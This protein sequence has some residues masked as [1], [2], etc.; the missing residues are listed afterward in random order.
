MKISL[1]THYSLIVAGIVVA[2]VVSLASLL[3]YQFNRYAID[4][5][6][7]SAEL[8]ESNLEEQLTTKGLSI[9]QPLAANLVN[10]LYLMDV[11]RIYRILR[12]VLN[13]PDVVNVSVFDAKGTLVHDGTKHI[14][15]F[16]EIVVSAQQLQQLQQL[17]Q[18]VISRPDNLLRLVS[19]IRIGDTLIGGAELVLDAHN[20]QHQIKE[21]DKR[22]VGIRR[23]GFREIFLLS[24][25]SVSV[26]GL[27][28]IAI[29]WGVSHR[30][31]G[32]IAQLST[33]ATRIGKGDYSDPPSLS[34]QDELGELARVF[35]HTATELQRTT[36]SRNFLDNVIDSMTEALLVADSS[37]R[38]TLANTRSC[39][40]LNYSERELLQ[41]RASDVVKVSEDIALLPASAEDTPMLRQAEGFLKAKGGEQI[42]AE[43]SCTR[44][45]S[46]DRPCEYLIVVQDI[47]E[48]K[49]SE[50]LI[51]YQAQYD[52]LT[53]LPNRRLLID[54]LSR[55][56]ARAKRHGH[57]GALLFIDLDQFKHINDS[58]G[59]SVGDKLLQA[60]A[61]RLK[62]CIREEDSV[63]RLGGD[64]FVIILSELSDDQDIH[65]EEARKVAEKLRQAIAEPIEV[66]G[67]KLRITPSIGIA[68]FPTENSTPELLLKY[69]DTA[70]YRAKDGGRNRVR[71]FQP[72]MQRIAERRLQLQE[73]LNRAT[74][75]NQL[76]L[77]AQPLL[78][79][80]RQ[81]FA[82]EILLRWQHPVEGLL[83]PGHFI[84]LAEETG[85]ILEIGEWV[86]RDSCR[87]LADQ[88]R[89]EATQR[90]QHLSVNISQRQFQHPRFVTMVE[91]IL[92]GSGAPPEC[93]T[94]ELTESIL[95]TNVEDAIDK[96]QHLK[97]LGV[98]FALDDFG[99]GYSSLS[100]LH[101]LPLDMIK[102]DRSF[103]KDAIH[104][105]SSAKIVATII[106]LAESLGLGVIAEGV[107]NEHHLQL[108]KQIRCTGYQG[109]LFGK[110]Q[111]LAELARQIEQSM[112]R[113][114]VQHS[115]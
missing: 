62:A 98:K 55:D 80:N 66:L 70:M 50:A 33:F 19:P 106:H 46:E 102:I 26:L 94:L 22:M 10:P 57:C 41:L 38:I 73:G 91:D 100:Y 56:L 43:I 60:V 71:F 6:K 111:P 92:R 37:G 65:S 1:R 18:P 110:P 101:R 27:L 5:S 9:V 74:S 14:P 90:L 47:T 39:K 4:L 3:F 34:R 51:R 86:L 53:D 21:S 113:L 83:T 8:I 109:Y 48:R 112:T 96:M 35:A 36:V 77:Y 25:E 28:A 81:V 88:H 78:D 12:V 95:M 24:L 40:L 52:P 59:H 69:A 87:F 44:L 23:Q 115:L 82:A 49:R 75:E 2:V 31:I 99:T 105:P 89:S 97:A 79:E 72:E 54:R 32:P 7:A 61:L 29:T 16:G 85:Q 84:R 103:V 68:L 20:I 17:A 58:L 30:I 63:A 67:N 114:A 15:R 107:E 42:A 64:E 104:N 93:L 45:A 108:L 11:D 76:A 13:Q